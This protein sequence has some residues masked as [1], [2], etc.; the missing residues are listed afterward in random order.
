MGSLIKFCMMVRRGGTATPICVRKVFKNSLFRPSPADA[1]S[2]SASLICRTKRYCTSSNGCR[3][4]CCKMSEGLRRDA[5]LG[6]SSASASAAV[7]TVCLASSV[8]PREGHALCRHPLAVE[9]AHGATAAARLHRQHHQAPHRRHPRRSS[10]ARREAEQRS[11]TAGARRSRGQRREPHRLLLHLHPPGL[12][13]HSGRRNP[14][15]K[16]HSPDPARQSRRWPPL[17]TA[18]RTSRRAAER[19]I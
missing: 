14:P 13:L 2:A 1:G 12:L 18:R 15:G 9:L 3:I 19:R 5:F 11:S 6:S 4:A 17:L 7:P 8:R 16:G 10:M